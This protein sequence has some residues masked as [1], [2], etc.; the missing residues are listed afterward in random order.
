M[1][2]S[3]C[4]VSPGW[5]GLRK[6]G[7]L[8]SKHRTD[9]TEQH[10]RQ[11]VSGRGANGRGDEQWGLLP[12]SRPLSIRQ[13]VVQQARRPDV[14]SIDRRLAPLWCFDSKMQD[15][16]LWSDRGS[17]IAVQ[18]RLAAYEHAVMLVLLLWHL[19]TGGTRC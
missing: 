12:W 9:W 14:S 19:L 17:L 4:F 3:C 6:R 13:D 1:E 2:S 10:I 5:A 8:P 15:G 11:S 16:P 18:K 7:P